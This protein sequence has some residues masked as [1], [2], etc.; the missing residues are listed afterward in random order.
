[1]FVEMAN[2][3][4]REQLMQRF[5]AA[6]KMLRE[7]AM[8]TDDI[9]SEFSQL[10]LGNGGFKSTFEI[11]VGRLEHLDFVCHIRRTAHEHRL[12]VPRG[13]K[14]RYAH[15]DAAALKYKAWNDGLYLSSREAY[16]KYVDGVR[17]RAL[18]VLK[19][20]RDRWIRALHRG[21]S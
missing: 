17:H 5:P 1:M 10:F 16:A 19:V 21:A 18:N 12:S 14:A 11:A 7:E 9:E 3:E 15:H 6:T 13:S 4:A 8:G 2:I 20:T